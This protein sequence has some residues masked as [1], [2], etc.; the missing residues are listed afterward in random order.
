MSKPEK[1]LSQIIESIDRW[2]AK[3]NKYLQKAI[4]RT[5]ENGYFS[6]EDVRHSI[7]V[8]NKELTRENLVEWGEE[9]GMFE[10]DGLQDNV[11][12]L[13]A[14]NLPLA[15]FQNALA[16][17]MSGG[18]YTGKISKKDPYLLPTFLNEVKKTE[19]WSDRDVQ[20]VHELEDLNMM[21]C[22]AVLFAGSRESVPKVK[23]KIKELKMEKHD[24]R[25]LVR[26]AHFSMTYMQEPDS[27]SL[28]HLTEAV[29]RYGGKGCRS[30]A[31]VVSPASLEQFKEPL[32]EKAEE[33]WKTNPQHEQPG[34]FLEHRYAF[35]ES[36]E[37]DQL[38]LED[39]LYQE[40]G[41]EFDHDFILY[42]KQGDQKQAAELA[43]EW[44]RQLQSIY[45]PDD[46]DITLDG[47]EKPVEP[48]SAAQSPPINWKPDGV[49]TLSW[50][51]QKQ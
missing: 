34:G 50:L 17:L 43:E 28:D 21:L 24:T 35:N 16:T 49:D 3:D 18:R 1:R 9:A 31:V 10:Q 38:W 37:R 39:F 46:S 12:C 25:Y 44:G 23:K 5:V 47:V 33:Y 48:L 51:L 45:V 29:L 41:F 22:D 11:L 26:T 20:W 27:E 7:Q 6:F 14:G 19:L 2:L 40:E 36:I 30:V 32:K 8:L 15:G 4:D 42:W 13:H